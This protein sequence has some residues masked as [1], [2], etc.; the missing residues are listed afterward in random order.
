[1]EPEADRR[2]VPP[3]VSYRAFRACVGRLRHGELPDRIGHAAL[4]S[5]LS[6]SVRTQVM[7]ALRFLGLVDELDG[8][9]DRLRA[10]LASYQTPAWRPSLADLV[11]DAYGALLAD[12]TPPAP[13]TAFAAALAER[14][15]T[16]QD[17]AR[18]CAAFF[19]HAA[20]DAGIDVVS[21]APR[22][23]ARRPKPGRTLVPAPAANGN[24][25]RH[26]RTASYDALLELLDPARMDE[27]EQT[28]VWTLIRYLKR[29]RTGR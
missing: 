9:T 26:G 29:T 12:V 27:R 8:P 21:G 10:M 16:K 23:G 1:M 24:G 14:Y 22:R 2:R 4:G 7:T 5:R 25:G 11:T 3:Y 17:V 20:R 19:V 13:P 15:R 6:P 28:A 18:K